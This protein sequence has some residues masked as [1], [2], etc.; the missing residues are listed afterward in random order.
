MS[1]V[2]NV[3]FVVLPLLNIWN[4]ALDK[5]MIRSS[6]SDFTYLL[7]F[8]EAFPATALVVALFALFLLS[9]VMAFLLRRWLGQCYGPAAVDEVI[10]NFIRDSGLFYGLM[11]VLSLQ[12]LGYIMENKPSVLF[13]ALRLF[14]SRRV[15]YYS[16]QSSSQR[17]EVF[18]PP[19]DGTREPVSGTVVFVHGGAWGSGSP[20]FYR[21]VALPFLKMNWAV[22]VVGY[23]VYPEGDVSIQAEDVEL[24][25][26]EMTRLYPNLLRG[27]VCLIGHSSGAHVCM[28]ALVERAR[29]EVELAR[30]GHKGVAK[31]SL[32]HLDHFCGISGPYNMSRHFDFEAGR[33]VEQISPLKPANGNSREMFLRYSPADQLADIAS[34]CTSSEERQVLSH[35]LPPMTLVHGMIDTTVPVSSTEEAAMVLQSTGVATC[36]TVC[37]KDTGHE[38]TIM[39]VMLGGQVQD[40]LAGMIQQL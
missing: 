9:H 38:E 6:P 31:S 29:R 22:S 17:M 34:Q 5:G 3:L 39:E 14:M 32:A 13:H 21:L 12:N 30:A 16:Q 4:V 33:E 20:A 11:S 2:L 28:V 1:F 25:V 7:G 10:H 8:S 36:E 24:A 15:V 18:F 26:A 23:R 40:V 35:S 37:V 27:K 19:L